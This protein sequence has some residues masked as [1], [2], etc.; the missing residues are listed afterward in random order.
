MKP[1]PPV[2]NTR[3]KR[4]AAMLSLCSAQLLPLA[5]IRVGGWFGLEPGRVCSASL[6]LAIRT[7]AHLEARVSALA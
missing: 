5:R 7:D 4:F 6:R 3:S 1:A 2:T